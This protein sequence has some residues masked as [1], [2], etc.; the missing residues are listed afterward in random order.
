MAGRDEASPA[1]SRAASHPPP[2]SHART[3]SSTAT[4]AATPR[5]IHATIFVVPSRSEPRFTHVRIFYRIYKCQTYC[6]KYYFLRSHVYFFRIFRFLSN[7]N[8]LYFVVFFAEYI[9][10]SINELERIFLAV[11]TWQNIF[12]RKEKWLPDYIR[13]ST[14]KTRSMSIKK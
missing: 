2:S 8:C 1:S 4:P 7:Q 10:A 5:G 9:S 3:P 6:Q 11:S 13:S 12:H 14:V